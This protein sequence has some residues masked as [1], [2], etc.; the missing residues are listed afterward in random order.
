MLLANFNRQHS[1]LAPA[2]LLSFCANASGSTWFALDDLGAGNELRL[3]ADT[4]SLRQTTTG[5]QIVV[6]LTYAQPRQHRWGAYFRSVIATVEFHCDGTLG[7][8]RDAVYYSD[9]RGTGLVAAREEGHAQVPQR[10]LELLPPKRLE[11]LTRAAC[12]QPMSA[13]P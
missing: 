3:E 8:Y 6:R 10:L 5:R 2:L 1:R 13:A 4:D 11:K 7:G 12:T 9:V